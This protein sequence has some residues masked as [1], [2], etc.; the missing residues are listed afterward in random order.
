MVTGCPICC[1][2]DFKTGKLWVPSWK[3]NEHTWA[4]DNNTYKNTEFGSVSNAPCAYIMDNN[5]NHNN[6]WL[7]C[8]NSQRAPLLFN[9]KCEDVWSTQGARHNRA[10]KKENVRA[11]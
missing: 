9:V 4:R 6:A 2:Q 8:S 1:C 7:P 10:R 11:S 5:N 3:Y